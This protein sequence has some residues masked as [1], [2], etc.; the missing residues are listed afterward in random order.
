MEAVPEGVAC[1]PPQALGVRVG[2]VFYDDGR[3]PETGVW[4]DYQ[5][6]WQLCLPSGPVLLTPQVWRELNR[7]VE[8]RL[9]KRRKRRFWR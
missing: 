7:A 5:E 1:E 4:I 9:R 2:P 8:K 6:A 3:P